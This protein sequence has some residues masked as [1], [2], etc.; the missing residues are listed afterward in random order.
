MG[1][2]EQWGAGL[3]VCLSAAEASAGALGYLRA[4]S[5]FAHD[6]NPALYHPLNLIDD[7]PTTL[8]CEGAEGEGEGESVRFYFKTRQKVDRIVVVPA[9]QSGRLVDSVQIDDGS[10]TIR[11]AIK[12][13]HPV[14]QRL[15]RP[16]EGVTYAVSISHVD[17]PNPDSKLDKDV[18]CLADVLLYFKNRLFGG[19]SSSDRLH[20]DPVRDRLLGPWSGEPFGAPEKFITFFLDG[21]WEWT[22]KPLL[23]GA[24]ARDFGEYRFRGAQLLMRRGEAGRWHEMRLVFRRVKVDAQEQGAPQGD[25]DT[26]RL[27]N[28]LGAN[29]GGLYDN[30]VF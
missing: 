13:S 9:V 6:S 29:M 14:E 26:F 12:G 22:F 21:T 4:S 8:W 28:A 3:L 30:A 24:G 23:G 27:N 10:N 16:L 2:A 18:A 19:K 7:D 15:D 20:Y 17:G 5:Q 25:Y 1:L 11:V